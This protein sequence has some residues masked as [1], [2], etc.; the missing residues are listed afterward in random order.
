MLG[1]HEE[2]AQVLLEVA[3]QERVLL[4]VVKL[5][6]HEQVLLGVGQVQFLLEVVEERLDHHIPPIDEHQALLGE[7]VRLLPGL[8]VDH[9]MQEAVVDLKEVVV[10]PQRH[11]EVE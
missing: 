3:K 8:V 4:G 5:T 1:E 9:L 6:K 2:L 11:Q 7:H 10:D